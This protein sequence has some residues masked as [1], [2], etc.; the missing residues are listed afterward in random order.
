MHAESRHLTPPSSR[1][2]YAVRSHLTPPASRSPHAAR[3]P[4]KFHRVMT[5]LDP[6]LTERRNPRTAEIDLATPLEI[7]D[8]IN[9]EDRAVADAVATQREPIAQAIERAE[10]TFRAGGRLFYIGAGT[11]GRLGVLDA[12][13]CPPTYGT[14]PEMVQGV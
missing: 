3:G 1:S 14:D 5:F 12:S 7:V 10:Q 9:A 2:P 8:L 11:S 13:E 6:R 4:G